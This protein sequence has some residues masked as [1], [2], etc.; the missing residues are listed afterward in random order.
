MKP[1]DRELV[2]ANVDASRDA[3][4]FPETVEDPAAISTVIAQ[5]RA[6]P[7]RP[8]ARHQ[9]GDPTRETSRER[10]GAA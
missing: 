6:T 5:L 9:P 2:H 4:H 10:E 3:Q 7:S 1:A 8:P